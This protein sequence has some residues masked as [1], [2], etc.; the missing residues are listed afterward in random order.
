METRLLPHSTQKIF[1]A[2]F[3]III[4]LSLGDLE[5]KVPHEEYHD[6]SVSSQGGRMRLEMCGHWV[7]SGW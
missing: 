6:S 3:T 1:F 7:T 4:L 5:Y 2:H